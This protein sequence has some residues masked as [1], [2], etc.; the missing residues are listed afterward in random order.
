VRQPAGGDSVDA[1]EFDRSDAPMASDDLLGII[2]QDR[3]TE[4][5]LLDALCNLA[6]LLF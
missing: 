2:H 5:K 1:K 4:A 6:N 3:I